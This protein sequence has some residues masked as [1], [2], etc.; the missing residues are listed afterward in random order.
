[1]IDHL[2][3]VGGDDAN[4]HKLSGALDAALGHSSEAVREYRTASHLDPS[5]ANLYSAALAELAFGSRPA[6]LAA[7]PAA[8]L[9]E[10]DAAT[11]L[12]P[13]SRELWLGRGIAA[14]LA[15][16]KSDAEDSLWKATTNAATN[17]LALTLLAMQD[18]GD[19]ALNRKTLLEL[20]RLAKQSSPNA[21]QDAIIHYDYAMVLG[22]SAAFDPSG[23]SPEL[24]RQQL[25][26]AVKE[27]PDFAAAHFELGVLASDS[28][29]ASIA[30]AELSRA[31]A[32]EDGIP[33]WHYRL[34]RAYKRLNQVPTAEKEFH[35]FQELKAAHAQ[36]AAAAR[37]GD[38]L[39]E[40]MPLGSL[41]ED[42]EVCPAPA[43]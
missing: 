11:K 30:V 41:I 43:R 4:T 33:E 1:L 16:R 13:E 29:N 37:L 8:A 21:G 28:D 18:G 14:L 20:E 15:G 27:Q 19:E 42:V 10:F 36:T 35:R 3:Q 38:Q 24:R 34:S 26:L 12:H 7:A 17:R 25:E 2:L 23:D 5:A 39:L 32:L 40:G 22:K 6:V 9:S 31:I